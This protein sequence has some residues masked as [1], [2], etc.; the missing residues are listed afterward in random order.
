MKKIK[1]KKSKHDKILRILKI[2]KSKS[3]G[4]YLLP[5]DFSKRFGVSIRTIQRD[6][7]IIR[8]VMGDNFF[9]KDFKIRNK[10][11]KMLAFGFVKLLD[12]SSL[13]SYNNDKNN[14]LKI[15]TITPKYRGDLKLSYMDK[16]AEAFELSRYVKIIYKSPSKA[17]SYEVEVIPIGVV[18][19]DGYL[20]FVAKKDTDKHPRTFRFDRIVSLKVMDKNIILSK[21]EINEI[22]ESCRYSIWSVR[23]EKPFINVELEAYEWASDFFENFEVL[24]EQKVFYL[25]NKNGLKVYGKVSNYNE[26]IPYILRFIPNVKVLKPKKLLQDIKDSVRRY[27]DLYE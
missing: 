25:K 11:L 18:Y 12:K 10:A 7:K 15:I 13:L 4:E 20:Y 24:A 16:I 27:L 14:S 8:E 22:L 23:S 17:E 6:F 9:E 3:D 2:L 5:I 26:I 19:F 21:D 1:I